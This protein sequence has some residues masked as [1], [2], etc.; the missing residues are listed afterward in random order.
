MKRFRLCLLIVAV[1]MVLP[2][3]VFPGDRHHLARESFFVV[4]PSL[5]AE[6]LAQEATEQ[7][8][9]LL[10]K[11]LDPAAP[12]GIDA[13]NGKGLNGGKWN[14]FGFQG[15]RM[16]LSRFAP[17]QGSNRGGPLVG[18]DPA[19]WSNFWSRFSRGALGKDDI[20]ALGEFLE[21][22]LNLGIEF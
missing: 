17:E 15:L 6:I 14:G 1:V 5:R 20:E 18:D 13:E 10:P 4:N 12:L 2:S 11:V 16:S 9:D 21:P 22:Q 3:L 7:G 8:D 19:A